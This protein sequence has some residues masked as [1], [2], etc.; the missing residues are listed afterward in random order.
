MGMFAWLLC[1]VLHCLDLL[2][3]FLYFKTY[4]YDTDDSKLS[5]VW[6]LFAET[7]LGVGISYHRL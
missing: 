6:G 5:L 3:S 7:M 1:A 2:K 4:Y